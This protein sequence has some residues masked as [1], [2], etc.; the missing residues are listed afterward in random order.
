MVVVN[1]A[2]DPAALIHVLT[3]LSAPDMVKEGEK[4]LKPFLK[5][6]SCILALINQIR[7]S[8]D[9][10]IRHHAA[11]LLKKRIAALFVKFTS[12]QKQDLKAQLLLLMTSESTKSIGVALAG[13]VTSIASRTPLSS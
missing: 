5:Q 2:S 4:L 9:G 1:L 13:S 10:A 7:T 8:P 12:P 11:L 3:M 6:P